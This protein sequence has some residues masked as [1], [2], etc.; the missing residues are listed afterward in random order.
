M[1]VSQNLPESYAWF[2]VALQYGHEP[3]QYMIDKLME[4]MTPH[5]VEAAG[6]RTTL[7]IEEISKSIQERHEWLTEN[8]FNN[9]PEY[10]EFNET[11]DQ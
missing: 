4:Q 5:Q 10:S 6:E 8:I 3:A 2:N 1:G 7:L 11:D 9:H